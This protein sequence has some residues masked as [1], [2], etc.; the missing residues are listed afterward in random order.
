ML[1]NFSWGNVSY[2]PLIGNQELTK[3]TNLSKTSLMNQGVCEVYGAMGK[4]LFPGACDSKAAVSM[5]TSI[6]VWVVS[7]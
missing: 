4:G 3:K 2:L 7:S 1:H 6:P 5:K